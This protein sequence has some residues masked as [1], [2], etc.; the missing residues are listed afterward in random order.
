MQTDRRVKFVN[1]QWG[2]IINIASGEIYAKIIE[3]YLE[4]TDVWNLFQ[5]ELGIRLIL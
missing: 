4:L 3:H 5:V 1:A 2:R